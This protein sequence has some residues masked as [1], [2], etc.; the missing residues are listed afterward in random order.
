MG[1]WSDCAGSLEAVV[2]IEGPLKRLKKAFFSFSL[3]IPRRLQTHCLMPLTP[4]VNLSFSVNLF[5][6]TQDYANVVNWEFVTLADT[7]VNYHN[8]LFSVLTNNILVVIFT[9]A[10]MS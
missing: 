4:K 10:F 9:L 8:I 2:E 5:S 1:G 3:L 6:H 7:T